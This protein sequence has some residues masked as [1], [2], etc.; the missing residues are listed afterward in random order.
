MQDVVK[1]LIEKNKTISTMESCTGGLIANSIT[2]IP[3]ASKIFSFSAVTYS[4]DFKIKMGVSKELIDKYSV[5]SMEVA[6]N[7]AY[8]IS[9]YTD[10][11][12]GIGVTGKLNK[13]DVN[14]LYGDDNLVFVSIY[15]QDNDFYY[16][17][18]VQLES[19]DRLV[20]KQIILDKV[21]LM[22]KEIIK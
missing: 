9:N 7:M 12:Y 20:N 5:Y 19:F 22:L 17:E 1:L 10:S 16:N 21:V 15:D 2:N 8:C 6:S 11:N 14:N 13:V 18:I 3:N 4:N